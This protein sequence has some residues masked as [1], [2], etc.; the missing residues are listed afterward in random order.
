MTSEKR[1]GI[2]ASLVLAPHVAGGMA[3]LALLPRGFA[4]VD[5]HFWANTFF[6]AAAV[7]LAV[8]AIVRI[9]FFGS[10]PT[11][12]AAL[13]GAAA[14]A[15]I[16]AAVAGLLCFP[17][18]I[19]IGRFA[20]AMVGGLAVLGVAIFVR[21][22]TAATVGAAIL[23]AGIGVVLVLAQRAP[24]PSTRPLGGTLADVRGGPTFDDAAAGQIVFPCGK[25]Q[26]RLKPLLTF[27][28]RSPDRTWTLLAPP[29]AF[30]ARRNLTWYSSTPGGFR[31]RYLDDGETTL[32]AQKDKSGVL[33]IDATSVLKQ[34]VYSH[35]NTFAEIHFTWSPTVAFGPTGETRFPVD[36]SDRPIQ[37]AYLGADLVFRVVRASSDEKGPYTPIASGHLGRDEP[38][39]IELRGDDAACRIV[40][41]DWAAQA[42]T[43]PSPTAG[44]GLPQNAI[45][46]FARGGEGAVMLSLAETGPGRGFDSVGHAAGV[47]KD[48][49]RVEPL[50]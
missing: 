44:W 33:D 39:S 46:F 38:L 34:P 2:V 35:L 11:L 40:F 6:P 27:L 29:D 5:I 28:S 24:E 30:G 14:G 3:A 18:S 42:S 9:A 23:G 41:K 1:A 48:R 21:Q 7:L 16:A 31:A 10:A 26:I 32:L 15:W 43:E 22:K 45:E 36:A 4:L 50:R 17:V 47:Y 8:V 49:I 19:T 25:K 12:P 13:V 37:I 20:G